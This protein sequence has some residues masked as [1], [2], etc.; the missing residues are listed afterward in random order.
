MFAKQIGLEHPSWGKAK[1]Y[2]EAQRQHPDLT[3]EWPEE[4]NPSPM[5][6]YT[7]PPPGKV[8]SSGYRYRGEVKAPAKSLREAAGLPIKVEA[9]K[10][11]P[12]LVHGPGISIW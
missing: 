10:D 12:I 7:P 5:P 3:E 9:S 1:C 4:A 6:A 8:A 11:R 2:A